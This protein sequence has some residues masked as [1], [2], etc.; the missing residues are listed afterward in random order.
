VGSRVAALLAMRTGA[1]RSL[2]VTVSVSFFFFFFPRTTRTRR[3]SCADEFCALSQPNTNAQARVSVSPPYPRVSSTGLTR[4]SA[5]HPS[6][7]SFS[8]IATGKRERRAPQGYLQ[9]YFF[10]NSR[11]FWQ[12]WRSECRAPSIGSTPPPLPAEAPCATRL[13]GTA[14]PREDPCR[15]QPHLEARSHYQR[16]T[17]QPNLLLLGMGRATR[18]RSYRHALARLAW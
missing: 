7:R 11:S 6:A 8:P 13:C 18:R 2:V 16:T 1:T 5:H 17:R 15:S 10:S 3:S 14:P 9:N 4:H 12:K